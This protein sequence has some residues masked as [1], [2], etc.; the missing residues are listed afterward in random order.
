M[1]AAAEADRPLVDES[2]DLKT[3]KTATA[4]A[5]ATVTERHAPTTEESDLQAEVGECAHL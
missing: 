3:T 1:T 5:T 4:T 2:A